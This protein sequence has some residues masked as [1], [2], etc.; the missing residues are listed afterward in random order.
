[1]VSFDDKIEIPVND[2]LT[3]GVMDRFKFDHLSS[4]PFRLRKTKSHLS[5]SG[6]RRL[7]FV[8]PID[9]FTLALGLRSFG[10]FCPKAIDESLQPLNFSLLVLVG[11]QNLFLARGFLSDIFVV[12][13]AVRYQFPLID[14]NDSL[15]EGIQERP[16]VRDEENRARNKYS[17]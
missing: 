12:I 8:H 1:M 5:F 3:V 15:G 6:V 9:L 14:L 13:A 17:R 16:V 11:S 2:V 10:V 4:A 7:D